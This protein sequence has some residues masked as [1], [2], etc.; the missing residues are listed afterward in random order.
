MIVEAV[1]H[2][3]DPV[4]DAGTRVLILGSL[5]GERSLARGQYYAHPQNQFWRLVGEVLGVAGHVMQP[6]PRS[7]WVAASSSYSSTVRCSPRRWGGGRA[8]LPAQ[9]LLPPWRRGA[10]CE[11]LKRA[12][13]RYRGRAGSARCGPRRGQAARAGTS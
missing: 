3:F 11:P 1:K 9:V 8:E 5:P 2:A 12:K 7:G 10:T 13:W 6:G 4:I